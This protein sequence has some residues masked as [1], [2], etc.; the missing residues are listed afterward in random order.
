[1]GQKLVLPTFGILSDYQRYS[2]IFWF[3]NT[4]LFNLVETV[5]HGHSF[6]HRHVNV[7]GESQV[8]GLLGDILH[9]HDQ[10]FD[11]MLDD[12]MLEADLHSGLSSQYFEEVAAIS[13]VVPE[14]EERI[15]D[16]LNTMF[17]TRLVEF[18]PEASRWHGRDL[19]VLPRS[20]Y[21]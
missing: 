12:P 3:L 13:L 10:M 20:F 1:M 17:R 11:R 16:M 9:H 8:Q 6:K 19:I 2:P 7:Y 4:G 14:I 5:V 18:V 21:L 15:A